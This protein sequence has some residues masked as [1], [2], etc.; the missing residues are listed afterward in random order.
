[1][2]RGIIWFINFKTGKKH[3]LREQ[4]CISGVFHHIISNWKWLKVQCSFFNE[5]KGIQWQFIG[6]KS[7]IKHFQ[8]DVRVT[9]QLHDI[10]HCATVVHHVPLAA[11]LAVF[12]TSFIL[13]L[14]YEVIIKM[15]NEL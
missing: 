8:D 12:Y 14:Q 7:G 15:W 10:L 9:Y 13:K 3:L 1:M 11:R 4:E 6:G 5:L 2:T